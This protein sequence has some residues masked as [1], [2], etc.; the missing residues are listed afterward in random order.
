MS[1]EM[2]IEHVDSLKRSTRDPVALRAQ[3]QRWLEGRLP[4]GAQPEVSDVTS[5]SATGMSSET[6]LFDVRW[7][8]QGRMRSGSFV[9]RLE[10]DP[11]DCPTFP[12]YDLGAQFRLLRLVR[13]RSD[14]PVPAA[15]WLEPDRRPLGA[16]FL[17]MERITGRVPPD[18]M[19]YTFGSW[20]S[21]AS[22]AERRHLQDSTV[23]ALA[24][25]H[26]IRIGAGGA[27]AGFLEF[28]VPGATPLRR[29]VEHQRRYYEWVRGARRHPVLERGFEWI[30]AHWPANEG[31]AVICWGDARIG[32]V[33]YDGFE[34]VA[35]LDW[36]MAALGPRELD[37]GWMIFLHVFFD[38]IAGMAGLPG[39]PDFMRREDVEAVYA[40]ASGH[41]PRDLSFYLVY[42]ALTHGIVMARVHARRVLFGEAAWPED[43]DSVIMHRRVLEQMIDGSDWTR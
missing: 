19:P 13:E 37:I 23:R 5:P 7:Q 14:V 26:G 22:P 32:N 42:A 35:L 18:V 43:V 9:A 41:A 38:E 39:L 30:E 33:I 1:S 15:L 28:D 10:P 27:D 36:E 25:L 20:V 8:E 17:V 24:A 3:L 16:P 4:A 34:P 2:P 21:E 40:D 11:R 31:E 12:V 6:L 29:H